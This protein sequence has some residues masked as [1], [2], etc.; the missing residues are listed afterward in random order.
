MVKAQRISFWLLSIPFNAEAF[1]SDG[2]EY[3]TVCDWIMMEDGSLYNLVKPV[4]TKSLVL[5][6]TEKLKLKVIY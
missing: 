6:R 5:L 1:Y 3:K 2:F 4:Y